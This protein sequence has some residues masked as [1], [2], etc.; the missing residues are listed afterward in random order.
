MLSHTLL[1]RIILSPKGLALAA[2]ALLAAH[3]ALGQDAGGAAA[4]PAAVP[5]P[6]GIAL[7]SIPNRSA[8]ITQYGANPDGVTMSTAGIQKAIDAIGN[9]GG[10][11][12][13]VPMGRFLTGPLT[14]ASN[15]DLHLEKG[16][17]LAMSSRPADFP[18]AGGNSA[19][20]IT[21]DNAHDI[22]LSGEGTIDG[23]GATWW[24]A[25]KAGKAAGVTSAPRRPQLIYISHCQRVEIEGITTLN[26]PNTHFSIR[27]SMD[28]TVHELTASAPGDSPNTDALNLNV[29]KNVLIEDCRIATGDDNIVLLGEHPYDASSVGVENVTVRNCRLGVG[30]GLSIGSF[31]AGGIRNVLFDNIAFDGTISGIRLKASRDRGGVVEGITYRNISMR[32]VRYPIYISSYYPR[33][34]AGPAEDLP[35]NGHRV[36]VWRD[37]TIQNL[38]ATGA[39]TATILWGLPDA[40]ISRVTYQN[41][42]IAAQ[43]GALLFH[44]KDVT[45]SDTDFEVSTGPILQLYD[46]AA[47]GLPGVPFSGAAANFR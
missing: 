4:S 2:I 29:V 24:K 14:L 6:A 19:S 16:A 30:H 1:K 31:T 36:P 7:P 21:A 38:T 47:N 46:A 39:R 42:H 26:P 44:A 22:R 33:E 3:C 9:A 10:G 11:R 32:N 8:D 28:I 12:V 27:Q 18:V 40:P 20:F 13:V 25:F 17:V 34:P 23:Q 41:V 35:A 5:S 43:E 37:I 15:I 45:F